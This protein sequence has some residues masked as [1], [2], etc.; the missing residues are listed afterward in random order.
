MSC[1]LC[2]VHGWIP[3]HWCTRTCPQRLG[4]EP[5]MFTI[6]SCNSC[7]MYPHCAAPALCGHPHVFNDLLSSLSN[8]PILDSP[9][10]VLEKPLHLNL[11]VPS[12]TITSIALKPISL[13]F[14]ILLAT[15]KSFHSSH[16]SSYL[17]FTLGAETSLLALPFLQY[18]STTLKWFSYI[19][20]LLKLI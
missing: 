7:V 16:F 4:H 8:H 5:V 1:A 10:R 11:W 3:Q 19:I 13:V 2:A 18:C 15:A 17:S 6:V 12:Y 14:S 20:V 9:F